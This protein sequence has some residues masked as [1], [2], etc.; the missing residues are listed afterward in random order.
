[1]FI[2]RQLIFYPV[3]IFIGVN[4]S[5]IT[6]GMIEIHVIKPDSV[7]YLNNGTPDQ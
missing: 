6:Q 4:L 5:Q 1:M 3:L 2:N 7:R